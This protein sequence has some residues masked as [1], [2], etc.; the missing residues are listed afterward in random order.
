[1]YA[2]IAIVAA[3]IACP[4]LQRVRAARSGASAEKAEDGKR[5]RYPGPNLAPFVVEVLGKPGQDAISQ[6]RFF[7]PT[8]RQ[9][10][11]KVLGAAW[12][13]L[14]VILQIAHAEQLLSASR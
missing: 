9:E 14:S 3:S 6:F 4:T 10:R 5:L 13:T 12:Q 8:G 2:D 11:S 7:A 1:M